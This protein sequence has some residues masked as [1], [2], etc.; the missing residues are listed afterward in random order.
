MPFLALSEGDVEHGTND[1]DS[2]LRW[3]LFVVPKQRNFVRCLGA[4][5][6]DVIGIP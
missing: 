1:S 4:D 2:K 6:I 3:C 5:S